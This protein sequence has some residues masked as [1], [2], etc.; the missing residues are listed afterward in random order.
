LLTLLCFQAIPIRQRHDSRAI[1]VSAFVAQ[2]E[3]PVSPR[4]EEAQPTLNMD[5]GRIGDIAKG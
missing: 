1:N 4:Y 2:A 5:I 3:D